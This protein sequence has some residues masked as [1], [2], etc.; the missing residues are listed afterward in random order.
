M[1]RTSDINFNDKDRIF[2]LRMLAT[3]GYII[4]SSYNLG[5]PTLIPKLLDPAFSVHMIL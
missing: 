2:K 5:E 3:L 4:R 1:V